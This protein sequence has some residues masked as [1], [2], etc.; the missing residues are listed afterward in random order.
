[1]SEKKCLASDGKTEL[2]PFDKVLVRDTNQWKWRCDIFSHTGKIWPYVCIGG[3]YHQCIPY[4]GN[5]HL[6]GTTD[7]PQP[8]KPLEWGDKVWVWEDNK[9]DATEALYLCDD[10]GVCCVVRKGSLLMTHW[11]HCERI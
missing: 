9:R 3:F 10:N 11:K 8:D 7:S 1:M 6:W 4:E 2:R 5:E